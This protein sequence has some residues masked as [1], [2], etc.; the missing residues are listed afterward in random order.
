MAAF[1][2]HLFVLLSLVPSCGRVHPQRGLTRPTERRLTTVRLRGTRVWGFLEV[3][4][5]SCTG[6]TAAAP[7]ISFS[8]K[9]VTWSSAMIAPYR[10]RPSGKAP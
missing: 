1:T 2:L 4:I 10:Q 3:G 7:G 5:A 9:S 8:L 6:R